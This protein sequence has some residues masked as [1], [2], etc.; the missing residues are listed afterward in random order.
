MVR[1]GKFLHFDFGLRI[2]NHAELNTKTTSV[3]ITRVEGTGY[4]REKVYRH[5]YA[6][7]E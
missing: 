5:R 3:V 6:K 1:A 2:E 7:I 4:S